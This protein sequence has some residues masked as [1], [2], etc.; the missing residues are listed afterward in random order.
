[1]IALKKAQMREKRRYIKGVGDA[2]TP[3]K[4]SFLLV[5]AFFSGLIAW[6]S[7]LGA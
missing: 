5:A 7:R 1:M 6:I 2:H 4:P 3:Y